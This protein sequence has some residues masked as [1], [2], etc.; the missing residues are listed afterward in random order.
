MF[1]RTSPIWLTYVSSLYFLPCSLYKFVLLLF[2]MT[3]PSKYTLFFSNHY[4][5]FHSALLLLSSSFSFKTCYCVILS[6]FF[7]LHCFF[8][9]TQLTPPYF[10]KK[11]WLHIKAYKA[12]SSFTFRIISP[13]YLPCLVSRLPIYTYF[14]T[15]SSVLILFTISSVTL[16]SSLPSPYSDSLSFLLF[17]TFH[18]YQVTSPAITVLSTSLETIHDI[19]KSS[20]S[21]PLST[22]ISKFFTTLS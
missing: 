14:F 3:K 12:L 21:L 9:H 13:S 10:V 5:I 15:C 19:Y 2:Y 16:S 6:F 22:T 7:L 4:I 20:L 1:L 11:F 17:P 8:Y 18:E